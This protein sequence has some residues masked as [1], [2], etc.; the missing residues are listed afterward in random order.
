MDAHSRWFSLVR[1]TTVNLNSLIPQNSWT[2]FNKKQSREKKIFKC[3]FSR[4]WYSHQ[5]SSCQTIVLH[6]LLGPEQIWLLFNCDCF[7]RF[8]EGFYFSYRKSD[9]KQWDASSLYAHL[10]KLV[11][12]AIHWIPDCGVTHLPGKDPRKTNTYF[13]FSSFSSITLANVF[14]YL[15]QTGLIFTLH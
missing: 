13:F 4:T 3:S 8:K 6:D 12:P 5:F 9:S 11:D 2:P 7:C 15:T 1:G 10:S 14:G